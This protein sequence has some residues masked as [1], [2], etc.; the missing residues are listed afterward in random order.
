MRIC[1]GCGVGYSQQQGVPR[2]PGKYCSMVCRI[3]FPKI[4]KGCRPRCNDGSLRFREVTFKDGT[5]HLQRYCIV[6]PRTHW[7]SARKLKK[8]GIKGINIKNRKAI[9]AA[10]SDRSEFLKKKYS[11]SFY[12]QR[13]WIKLRYE[14]FLRYGKKCH[15]CGDVSELMHVDHIRPRSKYP[16]LALD[17]NNLQILCAPCNLG[18]GAWDET[19]WRNS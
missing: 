8:M 6:C 16:K 11:E 5:I 17:I 10:C 3:Q 19:D 18:K 7:L 14:A 1:N 12:T 2:I 13:E 4:E 15:L 9:D